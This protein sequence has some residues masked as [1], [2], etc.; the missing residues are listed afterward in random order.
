MNEAHDWRHHIGWLRNVTVLE[1]PLVFD[2]RRQ[3]NDLEHTTS[4]P[5]D[6][7]PSHISTHP[8]LGRSV[9]HGVVELSGIASIARR[10]PGRY[11][12]PE[13]RETCP[14]RISTREEE[15]RKGREGS[16]PGD[17]TAHIADS[18]A[19]FRLD[20]IYIK[21][22]LYRIWSAVRCVRGRT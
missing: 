2:D 18:L 4:Q 11:A 16:G 8:I 14:C 7:C 6:P 20:R 5:S 1:D 15:W 10:E 12:L 17:V 19:D 13:W 3:V 22:A 21:V 9:Q